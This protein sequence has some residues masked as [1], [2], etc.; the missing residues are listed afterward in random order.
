MGELWKVTSFVVRGAGRAREVLLLRHPFAGVQFPAAT[1]EAGEAPE[2]AALR[3]AAEETGL[4]G[5]GPARAA[6]ET[7]EEL[8]APQWLVAAPAPVSFRPD[9]SRPDWADIVIRPGLTVRE[10]RAAGGFVQVTLEE[11]DQV[12][13]TRYMTFRLT[14]W[15]P[16]AALTR[17]RRRFFFVLPF[18]GETPAEWDHTDEGH[19]WTLFWAP[20]ATLPPIIPPQDQW[21]AFLQRAPQ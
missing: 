5:F 6:G 13:E 16:A 8:A 19:R 14:G 17:V 15:V 12:P 9:G 21:A 11:A 3:E 18:E 4:T 1:V 7:V 10:E 20:V 2:T